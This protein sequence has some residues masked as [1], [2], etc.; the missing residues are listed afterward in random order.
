MSFRP[1]HSFFFRSFFAFFSLFPLLIFAAWWGE[2]EQAIKNR[3]I[4][5]LQFIQNTFEVR[6]APIEWKKI[7]ANWDLYKESDIAKQKILNT[8]PLTIK[9][10]QNILADFLRSTKDYHVGIIYH[11]TE[12]AF[13]PFNIKSAQGKYFISKIYTQLPFLKVGD[14]IISFNGKN[15]DEVIG[16]LKNKYGLHASPET[17]QAQAELYLTLRLASLG[18]EVPKGKVTFKTKN[19]KSKIVTH[20][21]EW[22]YFPEK[23]NNHHSLVTKSH[24]IH[25]NNNDSEM[26]SKL[27]D[28]L[29]PPRIASYFLPYSS[30]KSLWMA[31]LEPSQIKFMEHSSKSQ[32]PALGK[33]IWEN[34]YNSIFYAYIYEYEGKKIGYLRIPDYMGSSREVA[35]FR[36]IIQRFQMQTQG[37]VI[38]QQDN[39]GGYNFYMY[40]LLTM[41]TDKPLA[42][43]K[44][45]FTITQEDVATAVDLLNDL[46]FLDQSKSLTE[47][48][49]NRKAKEALG[50]K[51]KGYPVTY[52]LAEQF[53]NYCHFIISEWSAGRYLT[54]PYFSDGIEQLF[55]HPEIHYTHPILV[56]IDALDMS[57]GD[58]F[59]AI[60]Q[61][62]KRATLIGTRTAGA[63]G[64]VKTVF[65]D[66]RFGISHF[67]YTGSWA[68]RSINQEPIENLGVTPD[69][70]YQIT[71]EDLQNNYSKYVAKINAVIKQH[72]K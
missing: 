26:Q 43:P 19:A 37:L 13:L 49:K 9:Q 39:S 18:M 23:I 44:E 45:R 10:F 54:H 27:L 65:F 51:I 41:L 40:A 1:L 62:N 11:S 38:D 61:D 34:S 28:F 71:Q 57:N 24:L 70:S 48:E 14:E 3:M 53:W 25:S 60:L 20:E 58:F 21:T 42:L 72:I 64:F 30:A 69:I 68:Q 36:E 56:I 35:A 2:G 31:S 59:P 4:S 6:Y 17:D 22:D 50:E 67:T 5:D 16:E 47:F 63:G 8:S 29:D 12:S 7:F 52:K 66:N 15:I 33:I 46:E 32:L 55:P